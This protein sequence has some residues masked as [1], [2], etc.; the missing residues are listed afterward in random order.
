MKIAITGSRN[1]PDGGEEVIC[2]RMND[3]VD[4]EEVETIYFGGARGSDTVALQAAGEK[5]SGAQPKLVGVVPWKI[6][7]QPNAG[8]ETLEDCAD[9]IVELEHDTPVGITRGYRARNA[10]MIERAD[11][12]IAFW[13]GNPGGTKNTIDTARDRKKTVDVVKL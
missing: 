6:E 3:L 9:S 7:D 11:E 5:R 2:E 13:N 1:I 10:E 12:L 8:Q 4:S